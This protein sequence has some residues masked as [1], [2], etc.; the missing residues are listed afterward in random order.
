MQEKLEQLSPAK[1]AAAAPPPA[2]TSGIDPAVIRRQAQKA[3]PTSK[4]EQERLFQQFMQ[5]SKQRSGQ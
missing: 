2:T 5:W 4:A 3:A 1:P